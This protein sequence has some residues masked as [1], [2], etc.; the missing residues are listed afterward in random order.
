MQGGVVSYDFVRCVDGTQVQCE[1][2]KGDISRDGG[3]GVSAVLSSVDAE[4]AK[5]DR[6]L[7]PR[8]L[9]AAL[10]L[11]CRLPLHPWARGLA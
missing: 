3:F 8:I 4:E 9:C 10:W 5:A 11:P 6:C 2:V 1:S 7:H